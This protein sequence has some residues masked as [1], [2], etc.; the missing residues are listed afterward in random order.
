MSIAALLLAALAGAGIGWAVARRR[1]GQG[2]APEVGPHL[3][4]DPALEWLR[5]SYDALG[6]WVAEL[7]P[8]E[9][10]PRAER[11]SDGDRSCGQ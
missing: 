1:A 10:G 8:H 11:I 4:P 5:R 9:E 2:I 3:L 6:V 7:D